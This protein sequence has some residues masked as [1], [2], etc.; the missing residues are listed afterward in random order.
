MVPMAIAKT[1]V[2]VCVSRAVTEWVNQLPG[3]STPEHGRESQLL[4]HA[5]AT[6]I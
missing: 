1:L 5:I 4:D 2:S 6:K 3:Q